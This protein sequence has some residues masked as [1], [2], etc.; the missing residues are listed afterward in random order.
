[1][2][3]AAGISALSVGVLFTFPADPAIWQS[4]TWILVAALACLLLL[5]PWAGYVLVANRTTRTW[6]RIASFLVGLACLLAVAVGSL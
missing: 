2:L 1:M 4:A 3:A 5:V 6:P